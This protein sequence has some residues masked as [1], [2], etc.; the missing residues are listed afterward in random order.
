MPEAPSEFHPEFS[1]ILALDDI[2]PGGLSLQLE[3]DEAARKRL[4]ARF[5]LLSLDRLVASLKVT[6]GASGIP[7]R[8]RGQLEA[9]VVQECVVSLEPIS[10]KIKEL[11][12]VEYAPA[13][14]DAEEEVFSLDQPDP[15]EP[16]EGDTLELGELVAQHLSIG[17]DPY[18][19]KAGAKAPEWDEIGPEAAEDASAGPFAVLEQLRKNRPS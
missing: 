15:P 8:V 3:A 2:P 10:S 19:R 18:P 4:A 17:L 14:E 9:S 11:I 16:L 1:Y 7:I 13:A 5:G 6:R 12:E